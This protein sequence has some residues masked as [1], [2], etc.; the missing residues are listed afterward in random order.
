MYF[1]QIWTRH[2]Q[3]RSESK[4][5]GSF[6][7]TASELSVL[8]PPIF[9]GITVVEDIVEATHSVCDVYWLENL[10]LRGGYKKDIMEYIQAKYPQLIGLYQQIYSRGDKTYWYEL[11]R[12]LGVYAKS[13]N[14]KMMNYFFHE[15]IKQQ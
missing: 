2:L 10:K 8:S 7:K 14:V 4:R 3:S 15:L 11:G 13:N 9:P 5:Y 6:A 12:K 1:G